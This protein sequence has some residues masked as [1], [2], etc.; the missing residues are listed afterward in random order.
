MTFRR[1]PQK[2][3]A[4]HLGSFLLANNPIEHRT[5]ADL[6]LDHFSSEIHYFYRLPSALSDSQKNLSNSCPLSGVL[7]LRMP[8]PS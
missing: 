2:Q 7:V 1:Y 4:R 8:I 6:M 5:N 3:S